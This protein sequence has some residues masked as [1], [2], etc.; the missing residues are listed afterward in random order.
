[1]QRIIKSFKFPFIQLFFKLTTTFATFFLLKFCVVNR[2]YLL[3]I[4]KIYFEMLEML[5]LC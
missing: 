5:K 2:F 1:M 4:V 3:L